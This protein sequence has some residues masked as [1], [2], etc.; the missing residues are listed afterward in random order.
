[1]GTPR[2]PNPVK[3]FIGML[4][5]DPRLFDRCAG[6]LADQYGPIELESPVQ[7]WSCSDYYREEMGAPLYRKFV[8]FRRLV[9]PG[10]LAAAKHRAG[11]VE[12]MLALPERDRLRR[13]VNLDPGYVDEAKVVLATTKDFAHRIYIGD[14]MYA[15]VTLRYR[16]AEQGFIALD[17]TYPDFRSAEVRAWFLEVRERLRAALRERTA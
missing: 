17:H 12:A 3:L 8:A 13:T 14:G 1:M 9:D 15:E 11:G 2:E 10:I 7:Q 4:S 6:L 16:K 5:V